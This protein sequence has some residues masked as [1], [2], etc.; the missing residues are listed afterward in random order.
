MRVMMRAGVMYE[1]SRGP[2]V[3]FLAIAAPGSAFPEEADASGVA[4]STVPTAAVTEGAAVRA[5]PAATAT[6][7]AAVSVVP[8]LAP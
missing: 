5:V 3:S 1:A 2:G 7:V 4:A 6:A 8:A